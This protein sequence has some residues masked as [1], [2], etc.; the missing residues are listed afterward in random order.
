MATLSDL[1]TFGSEIQGLVEIIPLEGDLGKILLEGDALPFKGMEFPTEQRLSTKYYPG[2]PVATQ[3]VGGPIKPPSTWMG[4]WMDV[5]LGE[6][7]ARQ[8]VLQFEYLC[9]RG[10]SVEV[11]WGGRQLANGED[12][13]VVRRGLIKKFTPK[14]QRA[15]DIEW[16]CEW[17]WRGEV[18]QTKPPTFAAEGFASSWDFS[19]LSDQMEDA[20]NETTSWIDA[21]WQLIGKG[22]DVLL[23]IN[24]A[25]DDVQNSIVDAINVVDG[26]SSMLSQVAE[27]P[28]SINQRIQGVGSRIVLACA[29]GRAAMDDFCGLWPGIGGAG[30]GQDFRETGMIFRQRAGEAKLA[31]YPHD[32]PLERLDGQTAQNDLI[33]SWDLLAEQAAVASAK[34]AAQQVPDVIAIERPSAG[35]DLRDLAVKFYGDP[36]LWLLIADYNDLDTSEVPATPTGPSD[37]GAPPIYI[38]RHTSTSADL[39]N[40]W[41]DAP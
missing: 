2:N 16:T 23:T 10:I 28:N 29:N 17:E 27:L 32:D 13:A 39:T 21:A 36:D 3:Q 14:Y 5:T 38:P 35:S 22:A 24:D 26:A 18:I 8:L 20:E 9:E 34:L 40:T 6:G 1:S 12:P 7:G 19:A 31:M 41:G 11:R 30:A 33:L 25:I 37:T 15:Q 4:H